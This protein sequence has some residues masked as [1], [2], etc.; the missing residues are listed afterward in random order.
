M[1]RWEYKRVRTSCELSIPEL[2]ELGASA[3]ELVSVVQ[4]TLD[5]SIG[6]ARIKT[7]LMIY[8]FKR[9]K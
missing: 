4:T 5:K 7:P 1:K 6:D 8:Y 9:Q 2:N 3:W